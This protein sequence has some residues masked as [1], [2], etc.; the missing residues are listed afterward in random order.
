MNDFN[1]DG[2][3][4]LT[5]DPGD[6]IG[7]A[8]FSPRGLIESGNMKVKGETL[9]E[10]TL[11]AADE[12]YDLAIKEFFDCVEEVYI[13]S[14]G[15]WG[16]TQRS[17]VSASTGK[18]FSVAYIVGALIHC[19]GLEIPIENIHLID[20]RKWKGN[21]NKDITSRRVERALGYKVKNEHECDSIGIGLSLM[22]KL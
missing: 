6:N 15:L 19:L 20:P 11:S 17:Q 2:K 18:I 7:W 10:K 5:I 1:V 21:M 4:F 3:S 9:P 14:V 12:I 22:G 13:E 16:N 8:F